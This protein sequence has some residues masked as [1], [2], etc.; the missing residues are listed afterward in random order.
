LRSLWSSRWD[1]DWNRQIN[2]YWDIRTFVLEILDDAEANEVFGGTTGAQGLKQTWRL[3]GAVEAASKHTR[4][5]PGG[6]GAEVPKCTVFGDWDQMG[7][8][9]SLTDVADFWARACSVSLGPMSIGLSERL[10]AIALVK[11]FAAAVPAAWGDG[12]MDSALGPSF[13]D[14]ASLALRKWIARANEISDVPQA[15]RDL[16]AVFGRINNRGQSLERFILAGAQALKDMDPVDDPE[17]DRSQDLMEKHHILRVKCKEN[18]IPAPSPYYALVKIDV[19]HLGKL[20]SAEH[21]TAVDAGYYSSVSTAMITYA[22]L[23]EET[24]KK[25]GGLVVYAGGDD[26]L[27]LMDVDSALLCAEELHT[28]FNGF[29]RD[30]ASTLSGVVLI[31]H[32][33]EHLGNVLKAANSAMSNVKE[34]GRNACEVRVW[35]HSG[36]P[37]G[38]I[39]GWDMLPLLRELSETLQN[40]AS[41]GWIQGFREKVRSRLHPDG[42][43]LEIEPLT[44][45][46][47]AFLNHGQGRNKPAQNAMKYAVRA[48]LKST[49]VFLTQ[50]HKDCRDLYPD[51][52]IH[53]L[54]FGLLCMDELL[55]GCEFASFLARKR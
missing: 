53:S 14:T 40:G 16:Q 13:R 21:A 52:A 45:L 20:L 37:V 17:I 39:V 6:I 11:R 42:S 32:Y 2:N 22:E 23:C 41:D 34:H 49:K 31:A 48:Y 18:G 27:A 12:L 5:F 38:S 9:G 8:R 3:A 28:R 24:I 1:E 50:R 15:Y 26:L 46:L 19:D 51:P 30:V 54:D 44:L 35:K 10:C 4:R 47:E 29:V 33:K 7:P 55:A 25:Y 43:T 36:A